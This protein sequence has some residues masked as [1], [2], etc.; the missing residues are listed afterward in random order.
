MKIFSSLLLLFSIQSFAC[1]WKPEVK[2]VV[3]LS[4]SMTVLMKKTG[5]LSKK[6]VQGISVFSP[7]SKNDFSGKIY[8]GGIFIAQGTLNEFS[9]TTV[10]YEKSEQLRKIFQSRND[11]NKVEI[12]TRG[13]VPLEVV[14]YSIEQLK[15]FVKGCEK[16]F[17]EFT[18]EAKAVQKKLLDKLSGKATVVFYLGEIRGNRFPEM[19]VVHDGVVSLLLKENKIQSYPSELAYV[20]WSAKVMADLPK[21]TLHVGLVDPGMNDEKKIKRSS[22]RMTLIY[23]G[24]LIPGFSQL[25]AFLYWAETIF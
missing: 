24:S 4:G 18:D 3:T 1:E 6:E 10:F 15:P 20:N 11:I 21:E 2:K 19:V 22:N 9:G 8:P 16:A 25:E 7:V 5:L 17:T 14:E 12:Y 13:K 23:P